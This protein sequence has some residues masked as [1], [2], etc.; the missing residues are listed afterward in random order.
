MPHAVHDTDLED[1]RP[2]NV[3][4]V[5]HEVE[6]WNNK[7][8]RKKLGEKT[9]ETTFAMSDLPPVNRIITSRTAYTLEDRSDRFNIYIADDGTVLGVNR[10]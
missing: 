6:E 3:P 4:P 2:V 1:A 9:D 8:K 5:D 10:G 7:L